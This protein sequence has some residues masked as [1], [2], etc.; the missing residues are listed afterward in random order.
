LVGAFAMGG[1]VWR[2]AASGWRCN[3]HDSFFRENLI[4]IR[5]E[6]GPPTVLY[7]EAFSFANLAS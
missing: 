6:L 5:A 4:A 1:T 7:P 2:K 3:S